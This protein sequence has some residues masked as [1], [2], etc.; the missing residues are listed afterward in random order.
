MTNHRSCPES[1][2]LDI[3]NLCVAFRCQASDR[4]LAVDDVSF[5]IGHGEAFGLIGETGSG[6]SAIAMAIL[7]LLPPTARLAGTI[8]LEGNDLLTQSNA[9]VRAIRGRRIALIPQSSSASFNPVTRIGRQLDQSI[10][11]RSDL[12]PLSRTKAGNALL[13]SMGF[14]DIR[15]I[16][17]AF[18]HELSGGMRQR[19]LTAFGMATG[20]P[21]LIADEPTKG[22]D[23][24][25][26]QQVVEVLRL[27]LKRTGAALLLITHDLDVARALC[28]RIGV[29]KNGRIVET[30]PTESLFSAPSAAMTQRL[31]SSWPA[32]LPIKPPPELA[33]DET[34]LIRADGVTMSYR[35]RIPFWRR[36]PAVKNVSVSVRAGETLALVGASGSGKS[37]LGRIL[38]GALAPDS[39]RVLVNGTDLTM[40]QRKPLARTVQLLFQHP[41]LSFD[42][43]RTLLSSVSEPF[44]LHRLGGRTEARLL[45]IN[46]AEQLSLS[47]SLLERYPHQV[48]GGQL[49]RAALARALAIN[50]RVIVLDEPTSLL[51]ASTQQEIVELLAATQRAHR[52]GY[53]FITH[54]LDLAAHVADTIAIMK[55]GCVVECGPSAA[56]LQTPQHS[57]TR[58]L[59]SAFNAM[60]LAS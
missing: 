24:I 53:V 33:G 18:P 22:L 56:I 26:R 17:G 29:M 41:E 51:D 16:R 59:L 52:L 2:L 1:A 27:A 14:G 38:A 19:V 21:L 60:R 49:Q 11:V 20:A 31:L 57:Y 50:P 15:A 6:K 46:L 9:G 42:P 37:T 10:A 25:L 55:D 36:P 32:K 44:L 30:A 58:D 54:D 47:P 3:Q 12:N 35:S 28:S 34:A 48:S 39:G 40:V 7:R 23:A 45:A 8:Q 43:Q 4:A 5:S 13:E